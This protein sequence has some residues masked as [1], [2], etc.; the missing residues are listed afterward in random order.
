MLD[1]DSVF[2]FRDITSDRYKCFRLR[3]E[4]LKVKNSKLNESTLKVLADTLDDMNI[5]TFGERYQLRLN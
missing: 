5:D 4:H 1:V 3:Q 2:S